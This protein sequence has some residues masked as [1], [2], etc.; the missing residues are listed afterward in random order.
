MERFERN[1][2]S[3]RP[4]LDFDNGVERDRM[5]AESGRM[6]REA[7][8]APSQD[9][10]QPVVAAACV[11]ARAGIAFVAGAR[12][13]VEIGAARPLQ[14]IAADGGS[15]AQLPRGSGQQRLGDR[16]KAAREIAVV[17]EVC[18]AYQRANAHAAVGKI[19]DPVEAGKMR[20]VDESCRRADSAL[21]RK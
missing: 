13:V 20:D 6:C 16:R 1:L 8:L 19:L 14:E 5:D 18:I 10:G 7:T 11:A 9:G 2:P 3:A 12:R 21:D 4:A 17:S 15:I